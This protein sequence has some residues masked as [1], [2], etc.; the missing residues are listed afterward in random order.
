[1]A[2]TC[3]PLCETEQQAQKNKKFKVVLWIALV[4]NTAMFCLELM[5]GA[6]A[7][8]SALWADA[9]DFFGDAV[10]YAMSLAVLGLTLVWRSWVALLKGV[11]M[12]SFGV[13]ILI[14]V[15][16]A[17]AMG[18]VPQ[19][20]MMGGIGFLALV[21]NLIVAI[22]LYTFR[23]GDA[24]MQSVWLCSRNDAIGNLAVMLAAVGVL[25]TGS[26]LPDVFVATI[27]VVLA[28]GAGRQVIKKARLELQRSAT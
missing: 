17:Y 28:I 23:D 2:C 15:A 5:A 24:N 4:L 1:M 19:P 21:A 9:L 14:K 13:I 22:L 10:N 12:L 7:N 6:V 3:G 18:V 11:V 25:G 20:I 27:M 16:L 8:S 26:L